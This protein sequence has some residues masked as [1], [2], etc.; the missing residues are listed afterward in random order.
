MAE[1]AIDTDRLFFALSDK[2]RR[3]LLAQ[4]AL[5]PRTVSDL[6]R[7]L[8]ISVAATMQHLAIL[9]ETRLAATEKSGRVRTCRIDSRGFN[10]LESWT[11]SHRTLWEM[12]VD[13]LGEMLGNIGQGGSTTGN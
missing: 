2:T 11:R 3:Q 9:E 7:A 10:A 13:R 12:R 6:A 1:A 5:G 8:G 4:L